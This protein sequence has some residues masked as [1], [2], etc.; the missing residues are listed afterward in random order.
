MTEPTIYEISS[1]GRI[2]VRFPESDVP[3]YTIPDELLRADLPF[4][5]L[6]EIDVIR[7]FTH[8][9]SKNY[10]IDKGFYPW[11]PAR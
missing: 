2:G 3:S 5:E 8:L 1:P 9:S 7:H 10:N 11:V 6:A 4:P